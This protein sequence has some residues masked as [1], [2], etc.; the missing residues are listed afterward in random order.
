[1]TLPRT[2]VTTGLLGELERFK[3]LIESLSPSE[4]ATPSRCTGWTV[5][6]VAAHVVG[7]MADVAAL[8][9]EGLGTPE[10]TERQVAQRRGRTPGEI[11]DE[12]RATVKATAD[13]L[14]AFDDT[15]WAMPSPGGFDFT[16][17]EGV[18]ALWHD[19]WLHG[20]DI[21]SAV[22]RPSDLGGG[23][24][25]SISHIADV[26]TRE[27]WGPAVLALDGLPEFPISGG[28]NGAGGTRFTGD[29]LAFVLAATGRAEPATVGLDERANIYR[30]SP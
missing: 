26:L 10:V 2:D 21:R 14:A 24:T 15:A 20:D 5:G 25:A 30:P 4:W 27:G 19:A 23:M 17:G 16:L 8:R 11:V 12:L 9:L 1:M 28:G 22:G 6:D 13:L 29:P 7:G 3:A 18:E